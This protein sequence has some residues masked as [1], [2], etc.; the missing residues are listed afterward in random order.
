MLTL[1]DLRTSKRNAI[2]SL[3]VRHGAHL[4]PRLRVDPSLL[5]A[6]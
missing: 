6:R 2:L 4:S 5:A 1:N 3:A